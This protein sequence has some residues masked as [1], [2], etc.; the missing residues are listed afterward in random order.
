M[1][2]LTWTLLIVSVA[3]LAGAVGTI[4]ALA[5]RRWEAAR[6]IA[7]NATLASVFALVMAMLFLVGAV[8]DPEEMSAFTGFAAGVDPS[9]K[10]TMISKAISEALNSSGLALP[11]ILI[12]GPLWAVAARK[13]RC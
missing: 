2:V 7:R 3:S 8:L 9:Q 13:A 5:R 12:A 4:V 10:A 11:A 6:V 1:P